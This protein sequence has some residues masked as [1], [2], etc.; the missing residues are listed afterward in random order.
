MQIVPQAMAEEAGKGSPSWLL[1]LPMLGEG[2][3]SSFL[4]LAALLLMGSNQHLEQLVLFPYLTGMPSPVI[5][6]E[7]LMRFGFALS[8]VSAKGAHLLIR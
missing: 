5:D 1:S 3:S 4:V 6:M 7:D 8:R 2:E